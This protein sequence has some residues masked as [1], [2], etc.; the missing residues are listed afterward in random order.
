MKSLK[1]KGWDLYFHPS[2]ADQYFDLQSK[3]A[4]LKEKLSDDDYKSHSDVKL[5]SSIVKII[6]DLIPSEPYAHYFVLHNDLKQY[7]HVKGKELPDRYRLFFKVFPNKKAIVI[8]WLGYPRKE[9]ARNDCYKVFSKRVAR[10]DF[11]GNFD[12]LMSMV[13]EFD[14]LD[15]GL[16]EDLAPPSL[17][18]N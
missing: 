4:K 6:C 18:Q 12:D 17:E 5:Y 11:P 3:V 14:S 10:G 13:S 8:L 9:D 1:V 2:F 15:N 16:N 7:S